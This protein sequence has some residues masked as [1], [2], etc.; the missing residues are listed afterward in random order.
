MCVT[1]FAKRDHF[2]QNICHLKK[3]LLKHIKK[4]GFVY[5]QLLYMHNYS[6]CIQNCFLICFNSGFFNKPGHKYFDRSGL[7]HTHTHTHTHT[8]IYR[9]TCI[10]MLQMLQFTLCILDRLRDQL[11]LSLNLAYLC[12]RQTFHVHVFLIVN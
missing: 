3:L 12:A 7:S 6:I 4:K 11:Y 5:I 2:C 8:Y 9:N 10:S 1:G